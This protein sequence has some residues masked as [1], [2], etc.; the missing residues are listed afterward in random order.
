MKSYIL[1]PQ[2]VSRLNN[3][4]KE[5]NTE[6]YG[7]VK[8]PANACMFCRIL[9]KVGDVVLSNSQTGHPKRY[10]WGCAKQVNLV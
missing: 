2:M 9:F 4:Q 6:R 1:T 8:N 10:H 5:I 3:R 7:C